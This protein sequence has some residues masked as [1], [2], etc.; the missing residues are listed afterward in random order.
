MGAG[1]ET[2]AG[3]SRA[4]KGKRLW[5]TEFGIGSKV[6]GAFNAPIADY[7]RFIRP[8][9]G[10]GLAAGHGA[11]VWEDLWEAFLDQVDDEY[12]DGNAVDALLLYSLREAGLAGLDMDDDD[13]S[14]M[15]V[16]HRDGAPRLQQHTLDRLHGLLA[17]VAGRSGPAEPAAPNPGA[18]L[19]RR[20][21]RERG[22]SPQT[23]EAN[24]MLSIEERQLLAWLTSDYWKGDG[25]IVDGGCF[26]GGSTLALAEGLRAS[27]RRGPEARIDVFDL[28]EVEPY[29][30]D[31]Y[32]G[33]RLQAGESFRG[34][35]DKATAAVSD[36]LRVH[37][38]DFTQSGWGG[39][40]IEVLFV[41]IS[42][43]WSL[44]DTVVREFAPCLIPNR[45]ILVQQDYAWP[46]Q[47]WIA[48]TMEHLRDYFEPV[49]FAEYNSV[50]FICREQVPR[51][52]PLPSDLP[53]E[54]KVSLLESATEHF[55]GY[56]RSYLEAGKAMLMLEQ[57]EVTDARVQFEAVRERFG[58]DQLAQV[59][60][61]LLEQALG[62]AA[63]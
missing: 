9:D 15:A 48:I 40:P 21:W 29:M 13:R 22:L 37:A 51:D 57:G 34:E 32:F 8:R 7:T 33:G 55:L 63:S 43:S 60:M 47:Y 54:R 59:P 16:L 62:P 39:D 20:P 56:P 23:L 53:Y 11:A 18:G 27:E 25:A 12:L 4:I 6:L 46:F 26:L 28:F 10:I 31:P 2:F 35:F 38:G 36:L 50:V 30:V 3:F 5:I 42:K 41:D 52:V 44:N 45:S 24:T 19:H 1:R 17:A 61:A 58:G 49:A 14:N